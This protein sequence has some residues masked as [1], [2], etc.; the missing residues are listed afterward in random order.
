MNTVMRQDPWG[1]MPRLQEEINRLFGNTRET[2]RGWREGKRQRQEWSADG[3][4]SEAGESHATPHSNR[5]LILLFD[6]Q[7]W[8]QTAPV[9]LSANCGEPRPCKL[10]RVRS[11]NSA[12]IMKPRPGAGS[13]ANSSDS[14]NG[15]MHRRP[16]SMG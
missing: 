1:V 12:F 16:T 3:H 10:S 4:N 5:C 9:L 6:A 11:G 7:A 14:C 8:W 15:L 2:D 13:S